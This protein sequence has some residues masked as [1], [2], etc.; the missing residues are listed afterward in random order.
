MI[1]KR[2]ILDTN[3]WIYFLISNNLG[4]KV[5]VEYAIQQPNSFRDR[6]SPVP[7]TRIV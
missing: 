7:T 6:S 5:R 1:S 2:I 3:L 4:K